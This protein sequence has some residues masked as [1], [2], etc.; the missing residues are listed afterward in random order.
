MPALNSTADMK[1]KYLRRIPLDPMTGKEAEWG[2]RSVTDPVDS[3]SWGGGNV[4]DI[5]SK[6]DGTA[7]DKTKYKDW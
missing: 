3:K 2:F 6:A 1:Y 4:F 5:Y 7:L